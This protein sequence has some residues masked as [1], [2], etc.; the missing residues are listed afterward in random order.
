MF[1]TVQMVLKKLLGGNLYFFN[2]TNLKSFDKFPKSILGDLPIEGCGFDSLVGMSDTIKVLQGSLI[3]SSENIKSGGLELI[4][5]EQ[6]ASIQAGGTN[7]KLL[8]P[9]QIINKYFGHPEK[10]FECQEELIEAGFEEYA[11]I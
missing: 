3:I 10:I 2:C 7:M 5:I 11:Q 8:K 4:N 6:M 1:L 9:F